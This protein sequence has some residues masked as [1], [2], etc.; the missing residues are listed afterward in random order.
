MHLMSG[1]VLVE[2]PSV[3]FQ[4]RAPS[5]RHVFSRCAWA[6]PCGGGGRSKASAVAPP[7]PEA[8]IRHASPPL[9]PSERSDDAGD[10]TLSPTSETRPSL[11]TGPPPLLLADS[12]TSLHSETSSWTTTT[13]EDD[14]TT[15]ETASFLQALAHI[16][17][18]ALPNLLSLQSPSPP[19]D[20][21]A[22]KPASDVCAPDADQIRASVTVLI[23]RRAELETEL[24]KLSMCVSACET[25]ERTLYDQ[26]R[27]VVQLGVRLRSL[28]DHVANQLQCLRDLSEVVNT[29]GEHVNIPR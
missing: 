6:F 2:P 12:M 3:S 26:Y 24:E 5:A 27:S 15:A 28:A 8:V 23:Q 25:Q 11:E 22:P 17:L 19:P 18:N 13:P 14:A 1:V 21:R 29:T 20:P 9:C 4:T 10:T 16:S 7:P